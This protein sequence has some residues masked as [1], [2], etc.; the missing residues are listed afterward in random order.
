MYPLSMGL[1][2]MSVMGSRPIWVALSFSG[3]DPILIS[4]VG[5]SMASVG[6]LGMKTMALHVAL[7]RSLAIVSSCLFMTIPR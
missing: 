2:R 6:E 3:A 7:L 4:F 5:R 1:L